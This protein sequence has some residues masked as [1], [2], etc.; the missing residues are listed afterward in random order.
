LIVD[1]GKLPGSRGTSQDEINALMV[2]HASRGR[3]VVRLKGGDPF[4][5]GRGA[6]EVEACQAAGICCTVVPGVS[7]AIAVP[8]A[9][10]IPVTARGEARSFAVI[11]A[12]GEGG[13]FPEALELLAGN[14]AIET[15]VVLMGRSVLPELTRA[16]IAAGRDP[17]TPAACIQDG[18]TPKQRVTVATLATLAEAADRDGLTSPVVTVIGAVAARAAGIAAC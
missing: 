2:E 8:A 3:A 12:Q 16:L 9:A 5:F 15:L 17:D 11:T 10:G 1:V 18:T 4:V 13:E 6:E 7:S 14:P